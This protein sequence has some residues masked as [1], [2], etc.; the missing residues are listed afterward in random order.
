MSTHNIW[1]RLYSD[2]LAPTRMQD[3]RDLLREFI[4]HGYETHS[5]ISFWRLLNSGLDISAGRHLILRH[6]VDLDCGA[7]KMMHDIEQQVGARSSFYFR[8]CTLDVDLMKQI[9]QSG[10]EASYHYEEL[11]TLIKRYRISSADE[12]ANIVKEAQSLFAVNYGILKEMTGLPLA[13]VASHGDFANRAVGIPNHYLL[14][15]QDLRDCLG[16]EVEAYDS[17]LMAPVVA[18]LSEGLYPMW[19]NPISPKDVLKRGDSVVYILTHPSRWRRN[20]VLRFGEDV[21]RVFEGLKYR[22]PLSGRNL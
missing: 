3:Y 21:K 9:E 6:D 4:D 5:I 2:Y 1:Y 20:I 15:S 22:L 11:A 17:K 13:G 12:V 7:A 10:S 16:I 14:Q 19:W 18:R 8:L